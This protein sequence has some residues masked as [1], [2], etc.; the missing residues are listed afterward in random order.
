MRGEEEMD[1][2]GVGLYVRVRA[3]V[4]VENVAGE[5]LNLSAAN[6]VR[7]LDQF[8][9]H[10]LPDEPMPLKGELCGRVL[11]SPTAGTCQTA[12][13]NGWPREKQQSWRSSFSS[14]SLYKGKMPPDSRNFHTRSIHF[15]PIGAIPVQ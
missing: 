15:L 8:R 11:S 12:S 1:K 10:G 9:G 7:G 5:S 6:P 14:G 3:T 4:G 13:V 2:V